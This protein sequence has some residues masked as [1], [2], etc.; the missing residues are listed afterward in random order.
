MVLHH[1]AKTKARAG[2]RQA[3]V[4]VTVQLLVAEAVAKRAF[5]VVRALVSRGISQIAKCREM[6]RELTDIAGRRA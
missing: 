6:R 3:P 5:V 2:P 4:F 1:G